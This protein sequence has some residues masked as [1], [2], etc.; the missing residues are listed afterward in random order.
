MDNAF[1]ILAGIKLDGLHN[2]LLY[3]TLVLW[4]S[5]P[6]DEPLR[7]SAN[8]SLIDKRFHIVQLVIVGFI[9]YH[10]Y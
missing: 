2:V 7:L 5:M 8:H 6:P 10:W 9:K 1:S 3:G 4:K